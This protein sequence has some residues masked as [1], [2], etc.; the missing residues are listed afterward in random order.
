M[1]KNLSRRQFLTAALGAGAVTALPLD[2]LHF[3]SSAK[4]AT[5][6]AAGTAAA[7]ATG[8]PPPVYYFSGQPERLATLQALAARIVPT[9][10]DLV[11][12]AVTSPG[13]AEALAYIYIDRLLG[14]FNLPTTVADNPA[15]YLQ[16]PYSGRNAFPDN[17]AG[18]PSTTFPPDSFFTAST[19]QAH[20]Q[21]LDAR[22]RL[23]WLAVLEGPDNALKTVPPAASAAWAAQVKSGALPAPPNG[24]LQLLYNQGLDAFD[25]YSQSTF[26]KP[27]AQAIPLE[28]DLMIETAGNMVVGQLPAPVPA[29]AKALFPT[30]VINVFQGTYGLP[31]YRDQTSTPIWADI[32]WDGDTQPL[33]S[34]IYDAKL[35]RPPPGQVSNRGFGDPAVYTP[36]GYYKE[37][38]P[39]STFDDNGTPTPDLGGL[40]L[41]ALVEYLLE[42]GLALVGIKP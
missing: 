25:S 6:A 24:G 32:G 8:S 22:Q 23:S 27:F 34:S 12:G 2:L 38:R 36:V 18:E 14:A 40:N 33:G 13:A 20:Y 15:I 4:A 19:G 7:A 28:Q 41:L 16:G 26:Q 35:R 29:A 1:S 10:T 5:G 37:F 30:L 42:Q 3:A 9:D 17:T 31:E 11:T 21:P 39:V